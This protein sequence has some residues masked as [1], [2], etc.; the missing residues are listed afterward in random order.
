MQV[1]ILIIAV[2][3]PPTAMTKTA[4]TISRQVM[5]NKQ[6][7][8]RPFTIPQYSVPDTL[9]KAGFANIHGAWQGAQ[10]KVYLLNSRVSS[11]YEHQSKI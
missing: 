1:P 7:K 11:G 6:G 8:Y 10:Q 9:L 2:H 4:T 5:E 3:I